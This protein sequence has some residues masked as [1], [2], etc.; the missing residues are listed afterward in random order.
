MEN[1]K[2][3]FCSVNTGCTKKFE[4]CISVLKRQIFEFYGEK[5]I[6]K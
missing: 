5:D 1:E 3:N 2:S 6:K 4:V